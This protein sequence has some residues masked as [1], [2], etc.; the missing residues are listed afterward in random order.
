MN[1]TWTCDQ[2]G[3]ENDENRLFCINNPGPS[4]P[5]RCTPE[6]DSFCHGKNPNDWEMTKDWP[7]HKHT[8]SHRPYVCSESSVY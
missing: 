6:N 5:R 3:T 8:P 1:N 4:D 7:S 2:C